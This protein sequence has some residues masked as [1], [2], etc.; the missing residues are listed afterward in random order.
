MVRNNLTIKNLA[1]RSRVR[2]RVCKRCN[3]FF[4]GQGGASVCPNCNRSRNGRPKN[5]YGEKLVYKK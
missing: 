3:D 2:L 4:R 1:T 5:K